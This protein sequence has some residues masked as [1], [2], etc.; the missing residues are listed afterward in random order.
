MTLSVISNQTSHLIIDQHF[1][2]SLNLS[3]D[4]SWF[5]PDFWRA[6]HAIK[7][8]ASGRGITYFVEQNAHTLVLRHYRRGGL[9]SRLSE[10]K[11]VYTGIK[12]TRPWQELSL[13]NHM[14]ALSLPVPVGIAGLVQQKGMT[15]SADILTLC[16]ANSQDI[17]SRLCQGAIHHSNWEKMGRAIRRLHDGQIYHHDLNIHNILQ[18]SA[19]KIWIIDFDKCRVRAG[20]SWKQDNIKRLLRSLEKERQQE[21]TYHYHDE[22]W[23]SLLKGYHQA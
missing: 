1:A 22:N 15:Y 14:N 2:Q 12:H 5:D 21:A 11:F 9:I 13:L 4:A 23:A 7:A 10:D 17:H 18:D 20:E 19:G 8:T 16:I 3:P 6:K